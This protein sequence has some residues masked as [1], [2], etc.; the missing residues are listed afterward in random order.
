MVP[1][2]ALKKLEP[3]AEDPGSTSSSSCKV[4][5]SVGVFTTNSL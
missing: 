2:G 5:V 3:T 4:G 1:D